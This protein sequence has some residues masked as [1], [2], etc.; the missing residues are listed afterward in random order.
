MS[1]KLKNLNNYLLI[2]LISNFLLNFTSI[3]GEKGQ[4]T[5]GSGVDDVD[6]VKSDGVD[7]F[8]SLLEFTFG[9]SDHLS[10]RALSIEFSGSAER[11]SEFSNSARGLFLSKFKFE[12][13]MSHL[14]DSDNIT[15]IDF[16][17]LD[18]F[19]HFLTKVIDGFHFSSLQSDFSGSGATCYSN[20]RMRGTK[21]SRHTCRLF[22]FD[23]NDLEK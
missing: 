6:F 13:G 20:F 8:L 22:D 14:V 11:S 4:E 12:K 10:L 15:S 19:D 18:G 1:G 9:A 17:L 5:L 16:F 2:D 21:R 23:F 7:N 3:T